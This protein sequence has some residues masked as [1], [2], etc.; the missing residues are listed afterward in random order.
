MGCVV[1]AV[2]FLV[3]EIHGKRWQFERALQVGMSQVEVQAAVGPPRQILNAG[4]ILER[5][6]SAKRRIVLVETWVYYVSPRS[7]H[8]EILEFQDNRL[9]QFEHQQN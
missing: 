7:Q 9:V 1:A 5:W 4:E 3:R 6:G 2:L 8:R